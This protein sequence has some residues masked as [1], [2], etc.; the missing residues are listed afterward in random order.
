MVLPKISSFCCIFF[1]LLLLF[2]QN[3]PIDSLSYQENSINRREALI[4]ATTAASALGGNSLL[5]T[6]SNAEDVL[7]ATPEVIDMAAI[8][9]AQ[10]ASQQAKK[11][12]TNTNNSMFPGMTGKKAFS[13]IPI[14]DP[15]P[16]LSIRGG[17]KN[18]STIKIPR[19]GYSFLKTNPDMAARAFALAL[20]AGVRHFDVATNY[21]SNEMIAVPLKRY[22]DVGFS[23]K[24]LQKEYYD[25]EKP[26]VLEY[27]DQ[28]TKDGEAHALATFGGSSTSS[29]G[30][31]APDGS[32]GRRGR[33][34]SLFLSHKV[35][36]QE[37]SST[38]PAQVRR[39]VKKQLSV[40]GIS[41]FDMV[42]LHSPLTDKQKRLTSYQALL[43]LRDQ[44]LIRSVGVCN[45]GLGPLNEIKESFGLVDLP[46]MN[47]IE[48]SPFNT[49]K[50]IIE[51]CDVNGVGIACSA[52][53]RLSSVDGPEKQW[54]IMS[55]EIATPHKITKAQGKTFLLYALYIIF[56]EFL[57]SN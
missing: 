16:L 15:P 4:A 30:T 23:D 41:Y 28:C 14:S 45:Y 13:I 54:Q 27:L 18:K 17:P 12:L 53:S 38:D 40:L 49:H 7:K 21:L 5:P 33:R 19:V 32:A 6:T 1:S 36:N 35:S 20:R 39:A 50:E 22:L 51:W 3:D 31:P 57:V 29:F 9:A 8:K 46:S 10:Q 42:S 25:I 2:I 44:G 24:I 34:E 47:Q 26:E 52:W 56:F 48:L 43:D 11:Q 55:D 37:Q